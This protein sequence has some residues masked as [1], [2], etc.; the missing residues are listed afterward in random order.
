MF[1]R[2]SRRIK[3]LESLLEIYKKRD[4][5]HTNVLRVLLNGRKRRRN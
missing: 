5:E 3:E 1:F 4:I 2:K